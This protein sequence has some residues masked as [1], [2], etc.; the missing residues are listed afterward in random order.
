MSKRKVM[1]TAAVVMAA[2]IITLFAMGR[3][4]QLPAHTNVGEMTDVNGSPIR[5]ED[6]RGKVVFVNNWASWCP[7]C[8]AEMPTIH[9]LKQKLKDKQVAFV[10]V[11]F[12]EDKGKATAFM[13]KKGYDFDVY[14]PGSDYP[15]P[16]S[17]IPATYILDRSGRVIN[18]HI[19]MADYSRDE[20][21]ELLKKL[22]DRDGAGK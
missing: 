20:F 18:E 22:A 21:V 5:F 1:I 7:P 16:T 11:S 2:G 12:D 17:S 13:R 3:R 8:I 10:M 4:E 15:F 14:F 6:F 9:A 19:G